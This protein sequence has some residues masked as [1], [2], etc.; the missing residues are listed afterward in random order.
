MTDAPQ[1]RSIRL[2]GY[3]YTQAGAY[4]VTVCTH[5]RACLFGDVDGENARLS[6]VGRIVASSW[7]WLAER[8]PYVETDL[9]VVMPNHLHGILWLVADPDRRGGS[10]A[11]PTPTPEG[12]RKPL[13]Q[14]IG[15]FKTV[16]TKRINNIRETPGTPIWQRNYYEHVIRNEDD[17]LEVRRYIRDNPA[18]WHDD[19]ENPQ[20]HR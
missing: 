10:R 2:P 15:A 16:S 20:R 3:D 12:R 7:E 18:R 8:Y 5:R 17:L 6:S 1:R 13:G 4:F 19:E 9:Y 11:A 14:L